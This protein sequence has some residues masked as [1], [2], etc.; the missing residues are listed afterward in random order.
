MGHGSEVPPGPGRGRGL[1]KGLT[2]KQRPDRMRFESITHK[3]GQGRM[4]DL[5]D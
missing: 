2:N 4:R 5:G 3:G 1:R